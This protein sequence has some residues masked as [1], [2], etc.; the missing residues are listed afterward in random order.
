MDIPD[1]TKQGRLAL[2][3]KS[4]NPYMVRID[5]IMRPE[6]RQD[7]GGVKKANQGT[8]KEAQP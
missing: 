1:R 7:S 8:K 2:P 6:E 3:G 4:E 5:R